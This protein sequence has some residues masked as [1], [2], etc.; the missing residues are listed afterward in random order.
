MRNYSELR[1][2]LSSEEMDNAQKMAID[3]KEDITFFKLYMNRNKKSCFSFDVT[4]S[5]GL[6]NKFLNDLWEN[7]YKYSIEELNIL[8]MEYIIVK[9]I[10]ETLDLDKK[11]YSKEEI[12][13]IY[14]YFL[15]TYNMKLEDYVTDFIN[16][17]ISCSKIL[18]ELRN[19]LS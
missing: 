13:T 12:I 7:N 6:C 16:C 11:H 9:K 10:M 17:S 18:E 2:Y 4:F 1:I 5:K 8:C 3:L 14:N 19:L 15:T